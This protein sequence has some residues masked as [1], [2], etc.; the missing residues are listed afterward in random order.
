[1]GMYDEPETKILSGFREAI[2]QA[3]H[4]YDLRLADIEKRLLRIEQQFGDL[5]ARLDLKK[6]FK[7]DKEV[8]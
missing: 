3:E 7:D 2:A 5:F 4:K 1:M 6:M 8:K